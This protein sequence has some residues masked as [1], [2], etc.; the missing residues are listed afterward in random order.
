MEVAAAYEALRDAGARAEYDAR[1]A[2]GAPPRPRHGRGFNPF[3]MWRNAAAAGS[4]GDVP[5][6]PDLI[7]PLPLTL[8]ELYS[9]VEVAKEFS[10][11]VRV[12]GVCVLLAGTCIPRRCVR[13][14]GCVLLMSRHGRPRR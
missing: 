11:R 12:R 14:S 9:G 7:V 5:R 2:A 4:G 13:A 6:L 3:D 10:R 1:A 8:A